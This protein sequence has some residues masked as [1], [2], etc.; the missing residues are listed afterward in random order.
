MIRPVPLTMHHAEMLAPYVRSSDCADLKTHDSTPWEALRHGVAMDG[1]SWAVMDGEVIIGA[2]GW[3][4][5]G[6]VW[7]LWADLS[8]T[9]AKEVLRMAPAWCRIMAIR[10]KR[11]LQNV[12]LAGNSQTEHFLR[13]TKCVDI[14]D[15]EVLYEGRTWIPFF[16]KPLE[17]MPSV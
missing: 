2:G 3:T 13:A 8:R 17:D 14:L 6:S 11:P 4:A 5:L 1:E 7:T 10:A 9:Q 15:Q 16:L 12:Y